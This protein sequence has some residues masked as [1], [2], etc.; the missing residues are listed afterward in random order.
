ME[1]PCLRSF[2]G[3]R[4]YGG[5]AAMTVWRSSSI[6]ILSIVLFSSCSKGMPESVSRHEPEAKSQDSTQAR[7][8][9]TTNELRIESIG[10]APGIW[11]DKATFA[12][13]DVA[14]PVVLNED[15]DSN[16]IRIRWWQ[17]LGKG[18]EWVSTNQGTGSPDGPYWISQVSSSQT[19]AC[20]GTEWCVG[21]TSTAMPNDTEIVQT[22]NGLELSVTLE[23]GKVKSLLLLAKSS[24]R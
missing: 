6:L 15:V 5:V 4:D 19:G 2:A 12:K 14:D 16:G 3:D 21:Q 23:A 18:F 22:R 10:A 9:P 17:H 8:A 7:P 20:F 24:P 11:V 13:L 1:S